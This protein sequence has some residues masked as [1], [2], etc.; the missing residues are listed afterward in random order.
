MINPNNRLHNLF[1][2]APASPKKRKLSGESG[3]SHHQHNHGKDE[4]NFSESSQE[5]DLKRKRQDV[6]QDE[7]AF[8]DMYGINTTVEGAM[9]R[10]R[11]LGI[12]TL[13]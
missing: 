10:A 8:A 12:P 9:A 7:R 13:A 2:G 11:K 1:G 3:N 4:Y 6:E 5:E